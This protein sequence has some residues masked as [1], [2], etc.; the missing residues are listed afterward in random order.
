LI[1]L[2][3]FLFLDYSARYIDPAVS[4][5][6]RQTDHPQSPILI[7]LILLKPSTQIGSHFRIES[8]HHRRQLC[9][10]LGPRFNQ[11]IGFIW[12]NIEI[13][14]ERTLLQGPIGSIIG[15]VSAVILPLFI[16][17]GYQLASVI[18]V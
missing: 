11:A 15:Q 7:K 12:V 6:L 18:E 13:E 10:Q 14:E 8:I 2:L 3:S 16:P 1:W 9:S 5:A 17:D 4:N